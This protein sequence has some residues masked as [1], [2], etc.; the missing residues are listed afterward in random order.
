[1]SEIPVQLP[2]ERP[3]KG[4][5]PK[6][7]L[8]IVISFR[9]ELQ[10]GQHPCNWEKKKQVTKSKKGKESGQ[11]GGQSSPEGKLLQDITDKVWLSSF[12]YHLSRKPLYRE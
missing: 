5:N 9:G 11:S 6:S 2:K 10:H 1:M 8:F 12:R 3:F 4:N 7:V